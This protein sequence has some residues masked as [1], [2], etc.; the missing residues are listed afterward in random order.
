MKTI[1]KQF[2]NSRLYPESSTGV[3]GMDAGESVSHS[4]DT[5]RLVVIDFL[6]WHA[7]RQE[8]LLQATEINKDIEYKNDCK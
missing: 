6:K 8:R 7:A 1:E 5:I 2:V 4:V 3:L